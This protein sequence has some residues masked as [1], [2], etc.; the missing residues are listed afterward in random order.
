MNTFF[1]FEGNKND[2]GIEE[3]DDEILEET[4]ENDNSRAIRR[5]NT[6][7]KKKRQEEIK[8]FKMMGSDSD[9]K[10]A[11]MCIEEKRLRKKVCVRK[12]RYSK[13]Q[14]NY[15]NYKKTAS[16]DG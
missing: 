10:L 16:L 11:N 12:A 5:K 13:E 6:Y 14:L 7:L 1:E 15:A 4:F 8:S 9:T 2:N 3:I